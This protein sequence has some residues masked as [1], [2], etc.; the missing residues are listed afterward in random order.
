MGVKFDFSDVS[1]A[2]DSFRKE[3][4]EAMAEVGKQAVQMAKVTGSY[5]NRTGNLRNAPGYGITEN[6]KLVSMDI[7]A[8]AA[9]QKAKDETEKIIR[10]SDLSGTSLILAD[11]MFYASFVEK[12]GYKVMFD[13]VVWARNELKKLA[14]Q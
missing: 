12:K 5:Q 1:A 3:V 9:H 10:K 4:S 6:G 8:D 13:S 2:I 14:K 7:P 11:G